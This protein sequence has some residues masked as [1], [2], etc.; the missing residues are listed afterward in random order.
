[1]HPR[2]KRSDHAPT[3]STPIKI[4]QPAGARGRRPPSGHT[5]EAVSVNQLNASASGPRSI[6]SAHQH[7]SDNAGMASSATAPE[8][9]D[10][11]NAS[12]VTADAGHNRSASSS[13]SFNDNSSQGTVLYKTELCRSFNEHGKPN[14]ISFCTH[15]RC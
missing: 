5:V 15:E 10:S 1:M 4:N 8:H 9:K 2:D 3:P 7:A 6:P 12:A 14:P 11:S 13:S